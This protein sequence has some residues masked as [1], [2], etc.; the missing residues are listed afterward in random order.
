MKNLILAV[1][2]ARSDL[3]VLKIKI[4]KFLTENL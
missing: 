3:K 4:L 2:L 1:I